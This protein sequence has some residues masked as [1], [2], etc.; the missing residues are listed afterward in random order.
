MDKNQGIPSRDSRTTSGMPQRYPIQPWDTTRVTQAGGYLAGVWGEDPVKLTL[1]LKMTRQDLTRTQM[2]LNTMKANF[3]DV[4]PRRD[5]EMQEKI[6][7]DL[8]EQVLVG[9]KV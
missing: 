4:I 9:R 5:F 7:K 3:G 2:E 1:A 8:Q 6:N